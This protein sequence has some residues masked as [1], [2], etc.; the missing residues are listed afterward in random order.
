MENHRLDFVEQQIQVLQGELNGVLQEM[1]VTIQGLAKVTKAALEVF[2]A[3]IRDL[4]KQAKH[5][6]IRSEEEG[7]EL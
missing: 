3:R 6:T 4:E 2:D 1:Q 5:T 7:K